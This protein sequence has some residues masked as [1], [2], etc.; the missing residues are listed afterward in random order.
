ML[1][2]APL[3]DFGRNA[4]DFRL[5]SFD[6]KLYSRGMNQS[7]QVFTDEESMYYIEDG[8]TVRVMTGEEALK[9]LAD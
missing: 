5:N 8:V 7:E 4:F 2:D 3:C 6:K 9:T 1:L